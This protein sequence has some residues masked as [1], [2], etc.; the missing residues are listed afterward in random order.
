MS[1]EGTIKYLLQEPFERSVQSICASLHN[2]G[3][4]IVG[5]VDVSR[6]LGRSLRMILAPCRIVFVLPLSTALNAQTIHPWAAVFLPLHIVIWG[7][8]CQCEIGIT[9]MLQTGRNGGNSS[10]FGPIVE[11]QRRLIE[12]IEAVAARPSVLA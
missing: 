6:R 7:N 4:R 1:A 5:E 9:N 11:A 8:D 10:S 12:A 2:H 3:M